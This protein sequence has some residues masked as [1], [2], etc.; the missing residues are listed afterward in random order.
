MVVE[1]RGTH[2]LANHLLV[3]QSIY[4]ICAAAGY[5]LRGHDRWRNI[6][7]MSSD[8]GDGTR[9]Q[10]HLGTRKVQNVSGHK[11]CFTHRSQLF[12]SKDVCSRGRG[13]GLP[14]AKVVRFRYVRGHFSHGRSGR[15]GATKPA[16]LASH[17]ND[18]CG[19]AARPMTEMR[20]EH[21]KLMMVGNEN[22][23]I[24]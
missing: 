8:N 23:R 15:G 16:A 14:R 5:G 21:G 10:T 1:R 9:H 20:G 18:S 7:N 2:A 12:F 17:S 13:C 22:S 6:R 3:G 19:Q 24:P 4:F 11:S